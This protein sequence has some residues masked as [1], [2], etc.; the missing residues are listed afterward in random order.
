MYTGNLFQKSSALLQQ[1]LLRTVTIFGVV[2]LE[3]LEREQTQRIL[4]EWEPKQAALE[5]GEMFGVGRLY[6]QETHVNSPAYWNSKLLDIQA[7]V[8]RGQLPSLFMI[9]TMNTK[10]DVLD[11]VGLDIDIRYS[12]CLVGDKHRLLN[13]PEKT[14]RVYNYIGKAILKDLLDNS[15]R[16]F[17]DKVCWNCR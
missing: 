7:L 8:S 5:D 11:S 15:K 1:L 17:C 3:F 13:R 4:E 14:A 9:I 6:L 12:F 16:Y 10:W 2:R